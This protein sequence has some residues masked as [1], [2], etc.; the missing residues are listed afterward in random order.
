MKTLL[1]FILVVM[2][3]SSRGDG[4]AAP[5]P[6]APAT[7]AAPSKAVA[8][9][10]KSSA[11]KA[12]RPAAKSSFVAKRESGYTEPYALYREAQNL[13]VPGQKYILKFEDEENRGQLAPTKDAGP[14]SVVFSS[15]DVG[16]YR[17]AFGEIGEYAKQVREKCSS[18]SNRL[19]V[20]TLDKYA[21]GV[22][23]FNRKGLP[24][25]G[26]ISERN[27]ALVL[28][29]NRT[30]LRDAAVLTSRY[31]NTKRQRFKESLD[32]FIDADSRLIQAMSTVAKVLRS[33]VEDEDWKRA[34]GVR[35]HSLEM[36]SMWPRTPI[37]EA[38]AR[39]NEGQ[40]AVCLADTEPAPAQVLSE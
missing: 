22:A 26:D 29:I 18:P 24:L 17:D 9:P 2:S 15:D 1:S 28:V 8:A 20:Q 31:L 19:F 25:V 23:S 33:E 32:R 36:V 27:D 11:R 4:T 37:F 39:L 14:Q 35:D 21:D 7:P 38:T 6:S 5:A 16:K 40:E 12:S 30:L 13:L 34:F 3:A 10:A